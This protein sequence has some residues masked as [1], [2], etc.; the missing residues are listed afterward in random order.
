VSLF[1]VEGKPGALGRIPPF[2]AHRA[3]VALVKMD[4][5]AEAP[6]RDAQG[7]CVPCGVNEV[8]EAL[9]KVLADRATGTTRFEG[10]TTAADTEQKILRDVVEPGDV[11]FRT[12]D[13]MRRDEQGYFHFV[14]RIGDTFRWKGENVATTDVVSTLCA[15]DAVTEATV[16]G[17]A[18]PGADG[19]AGMAAVVAD[20]PLD[21]AALRAHL[22]ASLPDYARPRFLR[23]RATLDVT[24][25]FKHTKQDLVRDGYDPRATDDPLYV[26]DPE[27][28]TFVRL[29]EPLHDRIQRGDLRL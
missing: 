21:V 27:R 25:T 28:H 24:G 4:L 7:R 5:A 13:L 15:F 3:P 19:R 12:G 10:Y 23:V 18:V 17:V 14:D 29:D 16:Y 2:L 8:G 22:C 6:A 20:G 11:W 1:N 26:D 9:G